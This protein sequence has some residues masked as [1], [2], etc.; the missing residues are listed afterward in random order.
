VPR[1]RAKAVP[2]YARIADELRAAI[3][4][5]ELAPGQRIPGEDELMATHGVARETARKALGVLKA[6]GLVESRRGQGTF[7]RSF[8]RILRDATTR[9]SDSARSGD[10]SIWAAE[11]GDRPYE[12]VDLEV[13]EAPPPK[14]IAAVFGASDE[15]PVVTRSRSY[16]VDGKPVMLATSYLPEAIASGT[17]IA[18]PDPGPGGIY[19]V[20][21]ELGF[22]PERFREDVCARMPLPEEAD[23]LELGT[24]IPVMAVARTAYT[25][26]GTPVEVNEMVMDASAYVVR[27]EFSS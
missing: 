5:G 26:D 2:V 19:K 4:G 7:V 24:G 14:R 20:L 11:L 18:L 1:K 6:E 25:V 23:L 10:A 27:Y 15:A 21:T 16:R 3:A 22:K 17:A 13:F 9:L 8:R 12:V